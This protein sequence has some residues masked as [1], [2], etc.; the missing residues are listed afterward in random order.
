MF[1]LQINS[2][3]TTKGMGRS[4]IY[5][6]N[7]DWV[8]KQPA[9][10]KKRKIQELIRELSKVLN[11]EKSQTS[12]AFLHSSNSDEKTEF[13]WQSQKPWDFPN[14]MVVRNQPCSTGD[15]GSIPGWGAKFTHTPE[16][17]SPPLCAC[18]N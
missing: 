6:K 7:N 5:K 2:R 14:G 1:K 10:Q 11:K 3:P 18:H 17:L 4:V 13:L 8:G 12:V 16:Q 9:S 15:A